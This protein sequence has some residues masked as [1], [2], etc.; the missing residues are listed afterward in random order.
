MPDLMIP[1]CVT[2]A[3]VGVGWLIA[4]AGPQDADAIGHTLSV[5]ALAIGLVVVAGVTAKLRARLGVGRMTHRVEARSQVER[6]N[7]VR[8]MRD[9]RGPAHR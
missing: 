6:P 3:F 2:A 4:H 7:P 8:P 1:L 5:F 9:G